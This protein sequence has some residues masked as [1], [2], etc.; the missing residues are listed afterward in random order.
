MGSALLGCLRTLRV[1]D[2]GATIN[3]YAILAALIAVALIAVVGA[4]AGP[5]AE[6]FT[7][8]AEGFDE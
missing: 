1:R 2:D 3:E 5:L 7:A 6:M 4:L 8:T